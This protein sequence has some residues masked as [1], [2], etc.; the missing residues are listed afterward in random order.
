METKAKFALLNLRVLASDMKGKN[1]LNNR[2]SSPD[3]MP[4]RN[5]KSYKGLEIRLT[6][7]DEPSFPKKIKGFRIFLLLYAARRAELGF[8]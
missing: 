4:P 3:D 8:L 1:W 5:T 6:Q 2:L 7:N